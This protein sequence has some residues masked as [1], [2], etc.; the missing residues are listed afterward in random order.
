MMKKIFAISSDKATNSTTFLKFHYGQVSIK[1]KCI[2][3][4]VTRS[5]PLCTI[6]MNRVTTTGKGKLYASD[7]N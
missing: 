3:L 6:M 4:L 1:G 2:I 5:T 7:G